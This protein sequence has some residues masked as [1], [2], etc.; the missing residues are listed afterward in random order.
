MSEAMGNLT[1]LGRVHVMGI[2]GAGMSGISR[3]LAARG[4]TVSGCDAKDSRRISALT[5]LGVEVQIGHSP[6]H[7]EDADTLIISTAIPASNAEL[8]AA[9]ERGI[10]IMS[11]A[12]ALSAIMLG[13]RALAVAGTQGKT[14]TTA[15]PTL[16][17]GRNS[18]PRRTKVTGHFWP[19]RHLR[20][21]LPTSR[22]IIST[23][24]RHSRP[25]RPR[26]WSSRQPSRNEA[27]SSQ[28]A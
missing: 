27:V 22:R 8:V 28:S 21:S 9:R 14:T 20:A 6:E 2:G 26:S 1:N 10:Q 12:D 23:T 5:A 18:L 15:T 24:G 17:R 19:C 3:I 4:V 11:R 25:S 16:A 7:A 13:Y